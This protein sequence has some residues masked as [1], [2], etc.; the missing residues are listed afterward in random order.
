MRIKSYKMLIAVLLLLSFFSGSLPIVANP[1]KRD[2]GP[3]AFTNVASQ[4]RTFIGYYRSIQLNPRQKMIM[5]EALGSIPA[6]CCKNFSARTCCCPCNFAKSLWGLSN[7]L[8]AKQHYNVAQ[9]RKAATQWISFTHSSGFAGDACQK[10]RCQ[11][12]TSKD[13]CG[14][15]NENNLVF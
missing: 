14:G 2:D 7:Y 10:G 11:L 4:T 1:A 3:L 6:P 5:D 12:P 8:I 13:G 15:M 9:V